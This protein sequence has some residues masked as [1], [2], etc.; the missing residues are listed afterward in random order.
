MR[1][2]VKKALACAAATCLAAG[3]TLAAG[4]SGGYYRADALE[5]DYSYSGEA[6]SN[7]GFAVEAGNYI[8]F[9]NGVASNSETNSYGDVQRGSL[10]RIAKSDLSAGNYSSVQTVV[11]LLMYGTDYDAGIYIYGDRVYYTTP[12]A[13]RDSN[14]ELLN[15]LLEFKSTKLD[16]TETM[17]DY[18]FRIEGT[19]LDY[20]IV[21]G[22]DGGIYLVY[23]LSETL[24]GTEAHTNIHSVNF[25]TGED[26]VIAYN[27]GSYMFDSKDPSNPYVYYTM[28]VTYNLGT[29]NAVEANY[30]QVYRV[31]ADAEAPREYDFSYIDDY[32]AEEDPLYINYGE[33]V[34]DGRGTLSGMT[35]FNYG[36]DASADLDPS[37]DDASTISGYTYTLVSYENGNLY[38]TREY[39]SGSNETPILLYA[40]DGEIGASGWNPVTGNPTAPAYGGSALLYIANDVDDY[41]F[42]T[43]ENNVPV[44]VIYTETSGDGY[45][46]MSSTFENGS[47][48]NT[49][50]MADVSGEVTVLDIVDQT[51][52]GASYTFLYFSVS[53]E[54]NGYTFHR[55]ALGGS[56][57]DY[58]QLPSLEE[59]ES[60]SNYKEVQILDLDAS[61]AWYMPEIVSDHLFF[62]SA[63][64]DMADYNYIMAFSLAGEDGAMSNEDIVALNDLYDDVIGDDESDPGVIASIDADDFENLPDALRYAFYTRDA[65][66]VS[67]LIAEWVA[68]GEDEEYLFSEESAGLYLDFIAA[69]G[70]YAEFA[71]YS[72]TV[73]GQTVYATSRDYF[74]ALVG[75]MSDDDAEAYID[76]L[77][78]DY[79]PDGPAESSSWFGGLSTG[80]KVG[81]IIGVCA[82]GLIVIAAAVVIPLVIVRKRR[83]RL[84]QYTRRVKVDTTDDKD[85]DVYGSDENSDTSNE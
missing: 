73:N 42:V 46:I 1:N 75:Y 13:A 71:E 57:D 12:S 59:T 44:S 36:Y 19:N 62:A 80:A 85:I 33:F 81:F 5:G 58:I 51:V 28:D 67:D 22:E 69:R 79:L 74:Y 26:T 47:L 4:C 61:S 65:E 64:D 84:P 55:I 30:N 21:E 48:V 11:P 50:P 78:A 32:D 14:G 20:R 56:E 25:E 10:V 54:G 34:F 76:A 60:H 77:K 38:Y 43:D 45:A 17:T 72:K 52:D 35:Q 70:D 41:T 15:S 6:V 16:G 18:Y 53:G 82:A 8:Y 68:E 27:V 40:T 39:Y 31:R 63:T 2:K 49:F 9:I 37:T 29:S 3:L 23:V 83:Q 66:A 24:Y 7:G